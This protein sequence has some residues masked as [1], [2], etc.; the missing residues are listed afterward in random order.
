MLVVVPAVQVTPPVT[1]YKDF[2]NVPPMKPPFTPNL[3]IGNQHL[4]EIKLPR[5]KVS[6]IPV[7]P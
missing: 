6:N 1:T 2:G 3:D 4:A 5:S 7:D